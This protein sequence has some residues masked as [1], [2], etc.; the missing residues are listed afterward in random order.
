MLRAC[1]DSAKLSIIVVTKNTEHQPHLQ[2][3]LASNF[4]T[5]QHSQPLGLVLEHLKRQG[6]TGVAEFPPQM[7]GWQLR[8]AGSQKLSCMPYRRKKPWGPQAP[9]VCAPGRAYKV[10]E[11]HQ[12]RCWGHSTSNIPSTENHRKQNSGTAGKGVRGWHFSLYCISGSCSFWTTILNI[13]S[14]A[15]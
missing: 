2:A 9:L 15:Q 7:L 5:L 6:L 1:Q 13:L 4:V 14:L 10:H 12:A 11:P 3:L 8:A